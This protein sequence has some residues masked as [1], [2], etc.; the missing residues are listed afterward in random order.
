MSEQ[1]IF[2]RLGQV[3]ERVFGRE[4]AL[5]KETTAQDVAGWDSL[6]HMQIV[7]EV[8]NEFAIKFL[9]PDVVRMQNVG[10]MADI[11]LSKC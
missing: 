9:L 8:E 3:F 4:V 6:N 1:E 11:V 2:S 10:D 7:M 5:T